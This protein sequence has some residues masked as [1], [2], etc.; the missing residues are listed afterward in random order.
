M[1]V[2]FKLRLIAGV[3]T[4]YEFTSQFFF[5]E[6]LTDTV[7]TQAPYSSRGQRD[8]RKTN[9]GIYNG[10]S[11]SAKTALT[12]QTTQVGNGYAGTIDLSVQ[13]G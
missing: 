7:Y 8:T 4:T 1:H 10:L 13:V 2:H 3:T 9:D 5:N 12:L 6:S 11:S